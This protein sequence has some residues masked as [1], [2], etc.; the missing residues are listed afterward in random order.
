MSKSYKVNWKD[1]EVT[2]VVISG[3]RY[4]TLD[5]IPDAADRTAVL[6]LIEQREDEEFDKAFSDKEFVAESQASQGQAALIPRIIVAVF[7]AVSVIMLGIAAVSATGAW[8]GLSREASAPASVVDFESYLDSSG[9][10]FYRPIVEYVM[11]DGAVQRAGLSESSTTPGYEIGQEIAILYDSEQ[12][13]H[14]RMDSRESA[15]L[16]WIVPIITGF[17][18][19]VF[20][21]ATLLAVWLLKPE[22]TGEAT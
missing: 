21:G 2:S 20:L 7:L 13:S 15:L 16:M 3:V 22:L 18:G 11:P 9:Q 6:K 14:A 4:R 1:G 19:V 17:I 10:R 5:Q 12:P 8:R